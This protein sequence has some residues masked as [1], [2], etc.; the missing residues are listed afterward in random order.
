MKF[1][2]AENSY[3]DAKFVIIGIPYEDAEMSFRKGT[4][5]APD[6]IRYESWNYESYDLRNNFD[7]STA[8]INDAG[9]FGLDEGRKFVNKVISDGKIPIIVGGA[10]SISP[11]ILPD[12]TGVVILDA[13]LD[14]RE[15]YLGDKNS[16]ACAARRIFERVGK[17]KIVSFGIRSA[18]KEEIG[19]AKKLGLKHF[20]AWEFKAGMAENI[21][22]DK[23]FLSIDMDVFDPCFAPGVSNPEPFGLGYEIFDF[24]KIISKKV[25]AMDVVEVC[26]PYDDGRASLLAA[27][28]IRDFISF[29]RF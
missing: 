6:H 5:F 15:E 9:N 17:E 13:H 8:K 26:P 7:L 2:D 3:E 20:Y 21:D 27:R 19:D 1:A 18:C 29:R 23:I 22:F 4:S 10:H 25:L 12:E 14:F 28:I 24:I 11:S 16:H